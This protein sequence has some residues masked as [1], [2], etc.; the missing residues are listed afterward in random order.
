MKYILTIAICAVFLMPMAVSAQ[1]GGLIPCN[2]PDCNTCHVVALA[3]NV[4][5]W[6]I[7]FLSIV[8][9]IGF[10]ISGFQLVTSGGDTGALSAAKARFTNVVIG[11]V[12]VLASWLIVDTIM[13]GLTGQGMS[14]WGT[15]ECKASAMNTTSD[16]NNPDAANPFPTTNS[17]GDTYTD[18]Q[19]R[20]IADDAGIGIWE[21]SPGA[22]SLNNINQATLDEAVRLKNSCNCKV[23]ITGGT[24]SGHAPGTYSH[25]TGYKVDL[26]DSPGLNTY[27]TS[28]ASY[29]ST[30]SDGAKIYKDPTRPNVEYARESSHWDISVY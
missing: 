12:L 30:R 4:V 19:A 14:M 15:V 18:A 17:N 7:T 16:G 22:T 25:S 8:A 6:L 5:N 2:G 24:E 26:E 3:N 10:V 13:L 11:I 29:V 21:S 27:I 28:N 9:V 23:T 1:A 20:A